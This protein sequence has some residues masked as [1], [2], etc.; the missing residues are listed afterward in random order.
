MYKY[1]VVKSSSTCVLENILTV[2][3]VVAGTRFS[4]K[5]VHEDFICTLGLH[6]TISEKEIKY[7]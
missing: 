1:T 3:R 7:Y 4:C 2:Q 5:H 6:T